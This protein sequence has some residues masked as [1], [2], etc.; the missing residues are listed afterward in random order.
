MTGWFTIDILA[1]APFDLIMNATKTNN[2]LRFARIGRLYKLVKLARL[3]RILKFIKNRSKLMK[4]IQDFLK[5]GIG[6]ERL[7]FF[8]FIFLLL[9]HIVTCLWIM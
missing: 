9:V 6:L 5:V 7:I 4:I 1:I 3:L 8:I 2:L